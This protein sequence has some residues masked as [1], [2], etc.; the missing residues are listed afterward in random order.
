[1]DPRWPNPWPPQPGLGSAEFAFWAA[2]SGACLF[3]RLRRSGKAP[4]RPQGTCGWLEAM[5]GGK[6]PKSVTWIH[7]TGLGSIRIISFST[8]TSGRPKTD[9]VLPFVVSD[10]CIQLKTSREF[11]GSQ[12]NHVKPQQKMG[13]WQL[14]YYK[15]GLQPKNYGVETVEELA[16]L[17]NDTVVI[18]PPKAPGPVRC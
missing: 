8:T 11:F 9:F 16:G 3:A 12:W 18:C 13:W 4:L 2:P 1:M 6:Q 15:K 17:V 7:M 14:R 10:V 5:K